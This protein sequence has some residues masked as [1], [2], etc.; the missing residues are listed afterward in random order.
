MMPALK[1]TLLTGSLTLGFLVLVWGY[2]PG[3]VSSQPQL[4]NTEALAPA[5]TTPAASKRI[6]LS[7]LVE[8]L[9]E[10]NVPPP[11][12]PEPLKPT[13]TFRPM[14]TTAALPTQDD[15]VGRP[16]KISPPP[17][18]PHTILDEGKVAQKIL[19]APYRPLPLMSLG[20]S[21]ARNRF[22]IPVE[23]K[24][25]VE[26]WRNVF[27]QHTHSQTI[28]HN[29]YY[30][31]IVYGVLDFSKLYDSPELGEMEI[32][33]VR[34]FTEEVN[35]EFLS[36]KFGLEADEVRAQWGQKDRFEEGLIRFGRYQRMLEEIF[37]SSGVPPEITRLTFVESMFTL[38]ALSKVGAAGPW[39]FMPGTAK[40][41]LRVNEVADERLDP[42]IAGQAAARL[43]KQNYEFLGTWPLAINAYNSGPLRMVR[44]VRQLGT[45]DIAT[46]IHEFEE[47]GYQFASR[48]FYPE[49]LAAIDVVQNAR[50]Y[51]GTLDLDEPVYF[52]ELI[53][54]QHASL[55]ELAR[56]TATDIAVLKDLNPSYFARY[57]AGNAYLPAGS[58]V[59]VPHR[60]KGLYLAEL[61]EIRERD[62]AAK[63]HIVGK[64]DTL[65]KIAARY[66]IPL[67]LLQKTIGLG[68]LSLREGQILK[69]PGAGEAIVLRPR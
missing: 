63:W 32:R 16:E 31:D 53:L 43:L 59:R 41:F 8:T 30:L 13:E 38:E 54:P 49:F 29:Q 55:A 15:V 19:L 25:E 47:R 14:E 62:K 58:M 3:K 17:P 5:M 28:L 10:P 57:F 2:L 20:L 18:K 7:E 40:K 66:Q 11:L 65:Q 51:F 64:R 48:N 39:Q 36:E 44:A 9:E 45:Q 6:S 23:L 69:I 4:M 21:R 24:K 37:A 46:I 52:D 27:A 33:R 67:P 22:P 60:Q 1:R 42:L 68:A 12:E 61:R 56:V 26:F 35:K 50:N 34:K